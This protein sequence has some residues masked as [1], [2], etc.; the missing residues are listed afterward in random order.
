MIAGLT[1]KSC[2]GKDTF[3]SLL[4]D[5]FTII[6]V[7]KLGHEALENSHQALREAFGPSIFT[8]EG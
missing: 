6:D 8:A 2:A 5:S 4:P 3:A 7:D 1:G